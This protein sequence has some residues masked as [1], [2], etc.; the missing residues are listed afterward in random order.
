MSPT[1]AE[2]CSEAMTIAVVAATLVLG[3]VPIVGSLSQELTFWPPRW[4]F[5]PPFNG[6][7]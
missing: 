5:T 3:Q 1:T 2:V 6:S 4:S 7:L